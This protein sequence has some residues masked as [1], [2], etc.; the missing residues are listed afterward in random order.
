MNKR[1][2]PGDWN[3]FWR[4]AGSHSVVSWKFTKDSRVR[5]SGNVTSYRGFRSIGELTKGPAVLTRP[6]SVLQLPLLQDQATQ[7][8]GDQ[9]W[10]L[11]RTLWNPINII[12]IVDAV[13]D[14]F[15]RDNGNWDQ[16]MNRFAG[17]VSIASLFLIFNSYYSI[18]LIHQIEIDM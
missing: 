16:D 6:D 14:L 13:S 15:P 8:A 3:R 1:R 5:G 10:C 9:T 12:Q 2:I 18:F 17:E 4:D 7:I 11:F